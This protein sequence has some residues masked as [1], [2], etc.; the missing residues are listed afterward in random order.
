[1]KT[2][3]T[4]QM[5]FSASHRYHQSKWS[6]RQ[7]DETFGACNNPHGHGHNYILEVEVTGPINEM[8]GMV[9]NL[10]DF[11][12]IL[13]TAV[14]PLDHRRLDVEIEFFHARIPTCENIA[15]Y[16]WEKL[17]VAFEAHAPVEV[18]RVR[19]Y[20]TPDLWGEVY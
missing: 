20:E 3:L 10:K 16:F 4:R 15:L 18:K 2:S 1:M 9:L 5:I 14:A 8:S 11:D 6:E 7:N 12:P 13:K 19:V 17:R